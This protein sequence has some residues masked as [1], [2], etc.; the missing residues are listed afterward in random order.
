MMH[1]DGR[2]LRALLA[3]VLAVTLALTLAPRSAHA[4]M[5]MSPGMRPSKPAAPPSNQPVTHAASGASDDVPKMTGAEPT[6]PADP[7]AMSDET[8]A[9]IGTDVDHDGEQGKGPKLVRHF[10][11]PWYDERSGDYSFRT[12]FPLWAERKQPNDRASLFGPLYF[13]RRSTHH[14][15][16]VAFPLFWNLRDDATKTTIVGPYVQRK[17]PGE[18]DHWLAPLVF[19]GTRPGGSYLHIPPLLTFTRH[20]DHSGLHI[21]GPAYC[22]WKGGSTCTPATAD[23]IDFGLAPFFFA[24]K[25]ERS[26][27][28]LVP[29]LL[30]YFRYDEV[31]DSSLNVWGPLLWK[32]TKKGDAFDILPLVFH[33][34]GPDEDHLTVFPFFHVGHAGASK[35]FVNPLFLTARGDNGESTFVTWGYARYRGRTEL[36]MITPLYWR[37][38]DPDIGLERKLL[39]PFLYSSKSPRGEDTAFFP[40][41][42]HSKRPDLTESTW[43]TPFFQHTHDLEGWQTNVHPFL[44]LGRTNASTHTVVAPFFW[45]FASPT[46]R[47]TVA[48]P[49]YWRFSDAETTSQLALNT[50]YHER[51]SR[52]G[53]DWEFHFFPAFSYGETPDGHWWNVFYGLAGYTRRGTLTKARVFWVPIPLSE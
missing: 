7:L 14:D 35:L 15:A 36:D 37:Y 47:A 4:Q 42:M 18:T 41:W 32:H 19:S 5:P 23:D 44:Y 45:D 6:L 29:P 25:S 31:E 48:F 46:S 27:Y 34:W 21:V 50:Y 33:S 17:A 28:E 22:S 51:R 3:C 30:H 9:R 10:Y 16:D 38:A 53:T 11:G 24:G 20:D 12:L 1:R 43:I 13:Q 52:A 26:R 40:F 49:F 2:A 39:F 8:R